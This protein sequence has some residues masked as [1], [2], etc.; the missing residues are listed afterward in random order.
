MA[1]GTSPPIG[2][3]SLSYGLDGTPAAITWDPLPLCGTWWQIEK[4]PRQCRQTE[5]RTLKGMAF[6]LLQWK[7]PPGDTAGRLSPS[8][9]AV[10]PTGG[11]RRVST[12]SRRIYFQ[13]GPAIPAVRLRVSTRW[14][15][16]EW[17][18]QI[19]KC[20]PPAFASRVVIR[21]WSGP[22]DSHVLR[23]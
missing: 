3:N 10:A 14:R 20:F 12:K 21:S 19:I 11:P 23:H 15:N 22:G 4:S 2:A 16:G 18:I 8:T 7:G 13:P 9:V 5:G 1:V 17:A 6:T